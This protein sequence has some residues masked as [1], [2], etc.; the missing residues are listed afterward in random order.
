MSYSIDV[1]GTSSDTSVSYT[2]P[3]FVGI[4]DAANES[5]QI[6]PNPA[7]DLVTVSFPTG[8]ELSRV[9]L[10]DLSGR[11]IATENINGKSN[12]AIF[13]TSAFTSG[14]YILRAVDTKG[15]AVTSKVM[16]AH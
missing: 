14:M 10:L 2:D 4:A 16:V 15:A 13:S 6:S 8:A 1:A 5:L 11:I 7:N 3:N 12:R 9:E